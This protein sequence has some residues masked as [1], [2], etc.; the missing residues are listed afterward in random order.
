MSNMKAGPYQ[1][2]GRRGSKKYFHAVADARYVIRKVL[3]IVDERAK[4]RGIHPL[5][6]QALLQIFGARKDVYVG[7]VA[8]R[9]DISGTFAS[10]IIKNLTKKGLIR[11]LKISKDHRMIHLGITE[12]G[13]T[14]MLE[15][16]Q[17]VERHVDAFVEGLHAIEKNAVLSIL[18]SYV[19]KKV[20]VRKSRPM[21]VGK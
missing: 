8:E 7:A 2:T 9:L 18:A 5:E 6:H 10:K 17:D 21:S 11:Q 19:G 3:R 14:L 20:A 12:K 13:K 16:D 15:I 4:R 1:L